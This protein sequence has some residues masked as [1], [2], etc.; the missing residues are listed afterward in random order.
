MSALD[1]RD[2]L[3]SLLGFASISGFAGASALVQAEALRAVTPGSVLVLYRV[4]LP[5]SAA[6][7]Q[8]WAKAG[9]TTQALAG[10]VVRQWRDGLGK[11]FGEH[12]RLLVG[13]GNWDDQLLLQGLAAEARRHPLLVMQHP[14]KAQQPGWADTHALELQALLQRVS[15]SQ[16]EQALQALAK[17]NHLQPGTPSLFSWIMG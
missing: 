12:K 10:D 4:D 11:E 5:E 16:Q 9:F 2:F 1:R 13:L 17:R 3:G 6:F 8:A 14:L 7:A 15:A